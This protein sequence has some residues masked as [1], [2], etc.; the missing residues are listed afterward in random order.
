MQR[1]FARSQ[2]GHGVRLQPVETCPANAFDNDDAETADVG[3]IV[4][5]TTAATTMRDVSPGRG[6]R[7]ISSS[8]L[9]HLH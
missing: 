2:L 4:C 7:I 3:W 9:L 6:I 5:R 1:V 8:L